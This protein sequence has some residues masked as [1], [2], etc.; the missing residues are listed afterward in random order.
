MRIQYVSDLHV[1][2]NMNH[3]L[4]R[5]IKPIEGSKI[6]V[7]AGDIAHG[8]YHGKEGFIANFAEC[9]PQKMEK[10]RK[11][12]EYLDAYFHENWEHV[13]YCYGNHDFY[14]GNL[15]VDYF[16]H[17]Q[18][19]GTLRFICSPLFSE[20]N[21][22]EILQQNKLPE[23]CRFMD[24]QWIYQRQ[25]EEGSG[26]KSIKR[27]IM[28]R[29]YVAYHHNCVKYIKDQLAALPEGMKAVVVTHHLPLDKCIEAKYRNS[30]CNQFFCNNLDHVFVENPDKI[31]AWLHGHSHGPQEFHAY[32][33]V[34]AR[35]PIGYL[36]YGEGRSYQ[37]QV[38]E[39]PKS[40]TVE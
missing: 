17:T 11:K 22:Q 7:V 3:S 32:G 33:A 29:E 30:G 18:D 6:L 8:F 26:L 35:N 9:K 13:V 20:L 37:N 38:I 23:S 36:E 28:A 34:V 39:I 21:E 16:G 19:I 27:G 31:A 40:S 25:E 10:I 1:D 4:D 12:I 24:L 15:P 5:K 14:H 2:E